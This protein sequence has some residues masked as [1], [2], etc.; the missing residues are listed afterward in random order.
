I[1]VSK[2]K[3]AAPHEI[4]GSCPAAVR[5]IAVSRMYSAAPISIR[6]AKK[7]KLCLKILRMRYIS[8]G[9]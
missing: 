3:S 8:C 5:V 9:G 2:T 1:V 7:H 6:K 4:T